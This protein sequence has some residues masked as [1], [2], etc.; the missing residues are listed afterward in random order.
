MQ[1]YLKAGERL[2]NGAIVTTYLAQAYNKITDRVEAFKAEGR[3]V[4]EYLLNGRHNLIANCSK[5]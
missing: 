4:P 3:I 5:V 1:T 2:W